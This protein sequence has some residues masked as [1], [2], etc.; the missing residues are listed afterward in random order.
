MINT[1]FV[2]VVPQDKDRGYMLLAGFDSKITQATCAKYSTLNVVTRESL[3]DAISRLKDQYKAT[4]IKDATSPALQRKLQK[5]FGEP[6][7]PKGK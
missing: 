6:V 5:L 1:I 2:R 3:N 7:T 4:E